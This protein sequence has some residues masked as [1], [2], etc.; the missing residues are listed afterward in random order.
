MTCSVM[1][2]TD[3]NAPGVFVPDLPVWDGTVAESFAGGDGTRDNPY[4]ISNGAE[5]ALL[6]KDINDTQKESEQGTAGKYYKLTNDI[7]LNDIS[8]YYEWSTEVA[9]KNEWTP[10]GAVVNYT[11]KGFAGYFDGNNYD[12]IGMYVNGGKE[13][14]NGLFG[15]LYSGQIKNLG[16]KYSYVYG[17]NSTSALAGYIRASSADVY[18]SG[19]TVDNTQ[20][21]GKNNVGAFGGYVESYIKKVI[22]D[23]C[24]TT[25]TVI[26]ANNYVGGIAGLAV[27][28]GAKFNTTTKTNYAI[29]FKNCEYSG[30]SS[31]YGRIGVGGIMGSSKDFVSPMSGSDKIALL[32]ENCICKSN[33]AS[34]SEHVGLIAGTIGPA[35]REDNAVITNMINCY[36]YEY[37]HELYG[38]T[39]AATDAS[40]SKLYSGFEMMDKENFDSFDFDTIWNIISNSAPSLRV[41]GDAL[42]EGKL[43]A[44]D[45]ISSL[46]VFVGGDISDFELANIDFD[47]DGEYS[48]A[49]V[50]R[51]M[52]Y[53]RSKGARSEASPS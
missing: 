7:L 45:L 24:A 47:G 41:L 46:S 22:F 43:T 1:A 9:P 20:I 39:L 26:E 11:P 17:G 29:E 37:S 10:G 15:Y 14:Y 4:L 12:I 16:I 5:L 13:N 30:D 3:P 21:Y 23:K 40:E 52:E 35:D 42:G 50:N 18:I 28:F 6:M 38:F 33:V 44:E 36:A 51:F 2:A 19:C 53:L 32:F 48:F 49:D 27:A 31:V 8:D 34:A 25:D